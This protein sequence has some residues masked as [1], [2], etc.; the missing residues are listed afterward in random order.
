MS[1]VSE[2]AERQAEVSAEK[3]RAVLMPVAVAV[4]LFVAIV[5]IQFSLV[6]GQYGFF[7]ELPL[8]IGFYYCY[9]WHGKLAARANAHAE[10]LKKG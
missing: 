8:G 4:L 3:T 6:L 7:A 5:F 2:R 9:A 1:T 10:K